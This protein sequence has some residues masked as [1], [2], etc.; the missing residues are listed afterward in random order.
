[1]SIPYLT[2]SIGFKNLTFA[3]SRQPWL[4]YSD[5]VGIPGVLYDL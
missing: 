1:M 3:D 5:Q 4:A 2:V